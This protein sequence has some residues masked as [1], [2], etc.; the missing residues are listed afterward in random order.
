[1]LP[2]AFLRL[3]LLLVTIV[4]T[5]ATSGPEWSLSEST[6]PRP[7][8]LEPGESVDAHVGLDGSHGIR[9]AFVLEK[10][11]ATEGT[12]RI[13]TVDSRAG[14][15]RREATF[16]TDGVDWLEMSGDLNVPVGHA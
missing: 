1:M 3:P 12:L 4:A 14:C 15:E 9:L 6:E 8:H 5:V 13:A 2:R 11:V 16:T 7:V 10:L